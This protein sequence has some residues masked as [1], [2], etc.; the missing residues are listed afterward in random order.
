MYNYNIDVF[1]LFGELGILFVFLAFVLL[2]FNLV[3]YVFGSL[4]IMETAKENKLPNPWLA[5]IPIANSYLLGK[6]GF[7]VYSEDDNKNTTFPWLMLGLSA[8]MLVI[9][10]ESEL[11][12]LLNVTLI[13]LSTI[14]YYRIYKYLTPKYKMYTVLSVFFGGIPLYFSKEM[15][16]PKEDNQ[17][18]EAEVLKEEKNKKSENEETKKDQSERPLY[19]SNCGNKLT[20]TSKY[21]NNC[22]RKID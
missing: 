7:E 5:F 6:L 8:C 9:D 21:C 3:L 20:K 10:N 22:G 12:D 16:K 2:I 13:V 14:S 18:N 19:C 17:V 11:Y 15:I 1:K 4:G